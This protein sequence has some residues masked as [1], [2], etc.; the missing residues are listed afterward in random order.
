MAEDAIEEETA[1][2]QIADAMALSQT[3]M[4]YQH[5]RTTGHSV[6]VI[7]ETEYKGF[8]DGFKHDPAVAEIAKKYTAAGSRKVLYDPTRYYLNIDILFDDYEKITGIHY[9]SDTVQKREKEKKEKIK[10][11]KNE[12]NEKIEIKDAGKKEPV[13]ILGRTK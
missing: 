12:E 5:N 7:D 8:L 4:Y 6:V 2:N 13:R 10:M 11:G 1:I 3:H 9:E